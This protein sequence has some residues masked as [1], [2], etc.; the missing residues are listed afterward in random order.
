MATYQNWQSILIVQGQNKEPNKESNK[1]SNEITLGEEFK[2][3]LNG[4]Q[5]EI[6]TYIYTKDKLLSLDNSNTAYSNNMAELAYSY[7][8][9]FFAYVPNN[10]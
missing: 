6:F 1:E 4:K 7:T 3:S 2:D 5:K 10:I 9:L 8:G